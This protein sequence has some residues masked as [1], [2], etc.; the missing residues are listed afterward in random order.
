M[1][2]VVSNTV[3]TPPIPVCGLALL[4]L[5]A[6]HLRFYISISVSVFLRLRS[7]LQRFLHLC[8]GGF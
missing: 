5:S 8:Q 3:L 2:W 1:G 6:L 4:K 7:L